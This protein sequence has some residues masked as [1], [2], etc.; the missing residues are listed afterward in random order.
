VSLLGKRLP[1]VQSLLVLEPLRG[2]CTEYSKFVYPVVGKCDVK[3]LVK[4]NEL[5]NRLRRTFVFE[6]SSLW[7]YYFGIVSFFAFVACC[8]KLISGLLMTFQDNHPSHLTGSTSPRRS[9]NRESSLISM[10]RFFLF[11]K[12]L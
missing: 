7:Y 2:Q 12:I 6:Q 10:S 3:N 5:Y 1:M 11:C 8:E 9:R 4:C